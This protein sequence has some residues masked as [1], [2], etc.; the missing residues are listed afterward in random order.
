[1]GIPQPQP[2]ALIPPL[3]SLGSSGH[4]GFGGMGHGQMALSDTSRVPDRAPIQ[5]SYSGSTD[6]YRYTL[7]VAQQPQRARMCGFGDKDRRPI[8]PPPC[9]KLELTD[10]A[11]NPVDID[12][13]DGSFFVLQVDLW[14]DSADREVNIVRASNSTPTTSIS[15][16]TTTSF[17]PTLEPP[18]EPMGYYAGAS[19]YGFANMGAHGQYPYGSGMHLPP[20]M[21]QP[22]PSYMPGAQS[23]GTMFTRNLIGS[24]TVNASRLNDPDNN[25]NYWFVL[26]D[27]SVRTEGFFRLKM[28]FIDVGATTGGG[29]NKG[30]APVLAWVFSDAFQVF[31]AKKFPGVIESTALSK[32]FASQGIKIPIRKDTKA[33]GDD[34]DE[35][36]G[37]TGKR[38]RI[39]GHDNDPHDAVPQ[40]AWTRC[41]DVADTRLETVR[42][43]DQAILTPEGH[44]DSHQCHDAPGSQI[45]SGANFSRWTENERFIAIEPASK[46]ISRFPMRDDCRSDFFSKTRHSPPLSYAMS[47]FCPDLT[48]ETKASPSR[49]SPPPLSVTVL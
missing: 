17:P 25:T 47:P 11:G 18:R 40:D 26:Q 42:P 20:H 34:D 7:V 23:S 12:S 44:A 31:S 1:M 6:K 43:S 14:S 15:T 41:E 30:K 27:L 19:G 10:L 16:A 3:T 49:A 37:L 9:I 5:M 39:D 2:G 33:D 48:D 32:C 45:S 13:I 28:N 35:G 38:D 46:P 24:L 22:V 4:A 21:G 36:L 29:L 8:T